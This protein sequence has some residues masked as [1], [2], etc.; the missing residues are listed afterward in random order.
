VLAILG[1]GMRAGFMQRPLPPLASEA[2][3]PA[4]VL[5]FPIVI[6]ISALVVEWS[7]GFG[8]KILINALLGVGVTL[9]VVFAALR[10]PLLRP[11]LGLRR[12]LRAATGGVDRERVWA[13]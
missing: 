3:L 7:L 12:P 5:H 1:V 8:A 10:F 13:G 6:G 9:L 2:A 4:Y 11:L